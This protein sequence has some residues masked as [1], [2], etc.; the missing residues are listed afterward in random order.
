MPDLFAKVGPLPAW[1]WGA[2]AVGGYLYWSHRQSV[3]SV[4]TGDGTVDTTDTSA[5]PDVTS[6]NDYGYSS[7]GVD[8]TSAGYDYSSVNDGSYTGTTTGTA[9]GSNQEWGVKAITTLISAGIPAST[10]TSGVTLY[11]AGSGLTADQANAVNEAI[12]LIG[13]PPLPMPVNL[14]TSTVPT[15][16]VV[17]L[18]PAPAPMPTPAPAPV[19]DTTPTPVT[20]APAP[21]TPTTT[22]PVTFTPPTYQ[23][24]SS[25]QNPYISSDGASLTATAVGT[26]IAKL[27]SHGIQATTV[28]KNGVLGWEGWAPNLWIYS[29]TPAGATDKLA[30]YRGALSTIVSPYSSAS[31]AQSAM[32]SL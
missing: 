11:L 14:I 6:T 7:S 27:A 32:A 21:N 15:Q 10:A 25:S 22:Q 24:G 31:S 5:V 26:V 9:F 12:T 28:N 2:I 13:P 4:P 1:A 16:P 8:P 3:V 30:P 20:V 18:D 17:S 29:P 19:V 23:Q